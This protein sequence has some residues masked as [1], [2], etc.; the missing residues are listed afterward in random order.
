VT[1]R[2]HAKAPTASI[3]LSK[4]GDQGPTHTSSAPTACK[5]H[6]GPIL[7]IDPG[8]KQSA[9]VLWDGQAVGASGIEANEILLAWLRRSWAPTHYLALEMVASYGM[10][11]GASTFQTVL[12]SGRFYEAWE[13][14]QGRTVRLTYRK[15][16]KMHLCGSM[17]AKDGNIRQALID[18]YGAPGIKAAPGVLYGVRSHVWAALAVA[19]TTWDQLC[20]STVQK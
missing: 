20:D 10:A 16:V 14:E 15:D 2:R 5:T 19:V 9:W 3:Q 6:L 4:T 11:V 8:T 7:A 1:T 12:W 13:R 18:R 17:R